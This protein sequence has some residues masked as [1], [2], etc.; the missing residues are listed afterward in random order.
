MV[1]LYI[2]GLFLIQKRSSV[3]T[4][5]LSFKFHELNNARVA[6]TNTP[7]KITLKDAGV[8]GN[9]DKVVV[10]PMVYTGFLQASNVNYVVV[11][12]LDANNTVTDRKKLFYFTYLQSAVSYNSENMVF[13]IQT[14]V[15]SAIQAKVDGFIGPNFGAFVQITGYYTTDCKI[16]S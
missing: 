1:I 10:F 4:F 13:P 2:P 7:V 6:V 14:G 3:N 8:P 15:S 5:L 12:L 16:V 11:D 9:A